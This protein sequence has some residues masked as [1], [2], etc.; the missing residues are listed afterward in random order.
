MGVQVFAQRFY[1]RCNRLGRRIGAI[2]RRVGVEF[3]DVVVVAT[4]ARER[5]RGH[6]AERQSETRRTERGR[7]VNGHQ[8]F[9][10]SFNSVPLGH[11]EHL[12]AWAERQAL[13]VRFEGLQACTKFF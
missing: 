12:H 1:L 4:T 7:R 13:E 9:V 3:V 5:A 11:L 2:S 6:E 8:V 10:R